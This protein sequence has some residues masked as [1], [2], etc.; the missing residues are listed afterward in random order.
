MFALCTR[1]GC[2]A[3]LYAY[4]VIILR[5]KLCRESLCPLQESVCWILT[6]QR[7]TYLTPRDH[8]ILGFT[9]PLIEERPFLNR[10][11]TKDGR[12]KFQVEHETV[13]LCFF[14]LF[15]FC[16]LFTVTTILDLC[17]RC[18]CTPHTPYQAQY[19]AATG[20]HKPCSIWPWTCYYTRRAP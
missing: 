9:C 16:F 4:N 18:K 17:S 12:T 2:W 14:C 3:I 8:E 1:L 5:V 20:P 19:K 10:C 7:L 6:L 15:L 13:F 11:E